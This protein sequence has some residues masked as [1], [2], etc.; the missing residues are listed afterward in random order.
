[1]PR[2]AF[3]D[4]LGIMAWVLLFGMCGL[5]A[6]AIRVYDEERD[7]AQACAEQPRPHCEAED[8]R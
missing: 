3:N 6:F 8:R 5:V 7:A 4:A 1:M 2:R